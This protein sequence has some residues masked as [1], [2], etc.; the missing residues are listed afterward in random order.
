MRLLADESV[1]QPIVDALRDAG[2]DVAYVREMMP[3]VDDDHVLDLAN[4]DARILVTNDKDFGKLVFLSGRVATG[5]LLIRVRRERT[6]EK[7][8]RIRALLEGG[9]GPLAGHFTV[10]G[11]TGIRRR[12]M[13]RA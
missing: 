8:R 11:A 10:L 3:G 5:I 2:H 4:E 13:R 9:L 7:L 6:S 12:P 1:E